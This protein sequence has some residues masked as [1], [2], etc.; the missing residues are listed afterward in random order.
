MQKQGLVA[1]S[2]LA[3]LISCIPCIVQAYDMTQGSDYK[4]SYAQTYSE[5]Q[6]AASGLT[7]TD[8][9]IVFARGRVAAA[10]KD[11]SNMGGVWCTYAKDDRNALQKMLNVQALQ[12]N[13]PSPATV[14]TG[15]IQDFTNMVNSAFSQLEALVKGL[16]GWD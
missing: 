14:D 15:P 5:D 4:W 10:E 12:R 1:C 16:F 3:I 8:D 13:N 2:I 7:I 6:L 11:C 9:D